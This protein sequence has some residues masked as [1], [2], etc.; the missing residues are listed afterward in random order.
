MAP[1]EFMNGGGAMRLPSASKSVAAWTGFV[2]GLI[3]LALTCGGIWL[4]AVGGSVAYVL[5]GLGI[6]V[7]GG[8]LIARRALALWVYAAVM[9][10]TIVWAV[11]EIGFDWWPLAARGD[12]I[13]PLGLWLLTPWVTRELRSGGR[14]CR[15]GLP[16][17][18]APSPW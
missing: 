4:T 12:V 1:N 17:A 16:P 6:M 3:G 2:Y 8:L 13:F 18:S 15:S 11:S 7:T 14:L 10:G 9:L 5:I